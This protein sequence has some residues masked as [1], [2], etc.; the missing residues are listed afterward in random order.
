MTVDKRSR[1]LMENYSHY[2]RL[3]DLRQCPDPTTYH[4]SPVGSR[5]RR[6]ILTFR[7]DIENIIYLNL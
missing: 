1:S 5:Q 6:G 4:L 3:S 7:A 2:N